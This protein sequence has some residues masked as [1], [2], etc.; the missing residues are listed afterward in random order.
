MV[1]DGAQ[2]VGS[3]AL[4]GARIGASLSAILADDAAE[5][6]TAVGVTLAEIGHRTSGCRVGVAHLTQRT[7]AA[8]ASSRV[9][10]IGRRMA[11]FLLAL[12]DVNA[13]AL[14]AG[15]IADA[16]KT[17]AVDAD[18]GLGRTVSVGAAAGATAAV[19]A[20]LTGQAVVIAV[21]GL[22]ALAGDAA[23]AAGTVSVVAARRVATLVRR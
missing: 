7:N 8:E 12:I 18:L 22:D 4:R 17:L 5:T 14:R 21:A 3:A 9:D 16:T 20:D 6:V 23:L 1:G 13:R 11:R 15:H 19:D 10:T 2:R